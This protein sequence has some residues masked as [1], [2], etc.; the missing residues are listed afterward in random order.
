MRQMSWQKT[1]SLSVLVVGGLSAGLLTVAVALYASIGLATQSSIEMAV[2]T[3][4]LLA[5]L[6]VSAAGTWIVA[7]MPRV[8]F[9]RL[10]SGVAAGFNAIWIF[11]FVGLPVVVASLIAIFISAVGVPR[12][13]TIAVMTTAIV[14]FGLGL[15]VLRLTE[16][17]GEHIFG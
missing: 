12:R 5:V 7:I 1:W 16:P 11:S 3:H 15:L 4:L 8:R 2:R 9:P 17:S 10:I 13:M 6:V 14:G